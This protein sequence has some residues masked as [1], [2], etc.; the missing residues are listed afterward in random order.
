MDQSPYDQWADIY[1]TVY[2]HVRDDIA[3]YLE[4]AN[5]ADGP[6]LEL[7]CGTGRVAI[8]VARSGVEV[9]GLDSSAA[10][11]DRAR[12][13]ARNLGLE[14]GSLT[15][16]QADMRDFCLPR[17]AREAQ[18]FQLVIVPFRGLLSLLTVED[19]VRTLERIKL[20]LAPGGRLVFNIFVPDLETLSQESDIL[21]HAR[22][23]TDP[24]TGASFVV[25]N[26]SRFD[27]HNQL[28]DTRVV[29]DELDDTGAVA[30]RLYRD[31]RLRYVHR[32]EMHH[33]LGLCG[34]EVVDLYGDFDRGPFDETSDEMVWVA[35]VPP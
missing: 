33:L 22:D 19:Q 32:W 23:V 6:V 15:L 29:V 9:V 18:K 21:Y 24:E 10:M 26:Q 17:L 30:N 25:W 12:R 4:E 35:A 14:E 34:Y 2:S 16:V 7:G 8:P 27:N 31:Y 1:D 5:R 13:K 3:F 20:H 28:V 11:L